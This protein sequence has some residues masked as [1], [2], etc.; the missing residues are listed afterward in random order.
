MIHPR[1]TT[2]ATVAFTATLAATL[3][4]GA[5]RADDALE[6]SLHHD[7]PIERQLRRLAIDLKGTVPS[8][9]EYEAVAGEDELP[10]AI[11]DDYLASDAFRVQMRNHHERLLWTNPLVSLGS[12]A[13]SLSS[14]TGTSGAVFFT[15]GRRG[16][17]RGG[18]GTHNCQDKPQSAIG[19]ETNGA[20][21]TEPMGVDGTGPWQAEGW[22]EVHPYWLADPAATIKVCAFDAQTPLTYSVT[23]ANGSTTTYSCHDVVSQGAAGAKVCGC[24]PNLDKCLLT[25]TTDPKIIA[26]LREQTLRLVDRHTTGG[27]PYSE[28]LTTKSIDYNGPLAHY[29]RHIAPRQTVSLTRNL[30]SPSDGPLPEL[31]FLDESTWITAER[32]D[33]HAGLLTLPAYL[34]RFQTLRGRANRYRIAFRGEYYQPPSAKDTNCAKEGGD[35]TK[36]C[37]CRGC[38]TSLEPLSAHFGKFVEQGSQSL[39]DFA[40][41]YPT[42]SA[43]NAQVAPASTSYCDRYYV[44]VPSLADPDLRPFRL[45]ALEYA[46]ADHPEIEPNFEAGPSGL[47]EGDIASGLFHEVAVEHLFELLMKREPVLDVTSPDF[48]GDVLAEIAADFRQHDDLRLAVR[49]L[50]KLPAYR[51]MR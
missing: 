13:H 35:L 23:A 32:G 46:D 19:W 29:F 8:V 26:A 45:R 47:A 31:A 21:K 15:T 51:R 37:V 28:L 14:F 49:D 17:Y 1:R 7:L 3:A 50:V 41:E 43:C 22:V 38:H 11:L 36:R 20:P 18:D 30:H 24:G 4:P 44:S 16:L 6:C 39:A 34:L 27:E 48:E 5:L 2:R 33:P 42:R 25:S 10:D 40:L 9:D 12:V